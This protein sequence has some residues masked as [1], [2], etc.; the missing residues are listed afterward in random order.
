M[1]SIALL[2]HMIRE[3]RHCSSFIWSLHLLTCT[4]LLIIFL[5]I[6]ANPN[7]LNHSYGVL[8]FHLMLS[9]RFICLHIHGINDYVPHYDTVTRLNYIEHLCNRIVKLKRTDILSGPRHLGDSFTRDHTLINSSFVLSAIMLPNINLR[10]IL[11]TV[12]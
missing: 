4:F 1:I 11:D 12:G 8:Y 10:P 9:K 6:K 5:L 3:S 2:V 7:R